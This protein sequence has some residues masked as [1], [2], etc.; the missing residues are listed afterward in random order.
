MRG[1]DSFLRHSYP[2]LKMAAPYTH[3]ADDIASHSPDTAFS[4]FKEPYE[5]KVD[6]AE[7]ALKNLPLN[8][9]FSEEDGVTDKCTYLAAP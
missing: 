3:I 4:E 7:D 9:N 6:E 2:T 5:I 8:R 1:F